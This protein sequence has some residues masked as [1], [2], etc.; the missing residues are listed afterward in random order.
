[1]RFSRRVHIASIGVSLGLAILQLASPAKA[2]L[3]TALE[4]R[5]LSPEQAELRPAVD[6]KGVVIFSDPPHTIFI[7]DGTAGTFFRWGNGV[8]PK[9]GDEVQVRGK[10]FPG[11]Y[12]S[13]IENATFEVLAHPGM[14]EALPATYDD[15]MSGRLHYQRV[16]VEG[17]VRTIVP[18]GEGTSLLRIALGSRIVEVQMNQPIET[19]STDWI[20][21]RVK[22]SGLAAGRINARR[23]LVAPY[24]RCRGWSEIVPLSAPV[25]AEAIPNASPEQLLNFAVDGHEGHRVRV[26]GVVLASFNNRELFV[27]D[28]ESAIQVHLFQLPPELKPSPGDL[29][30]VLGFPQM[31]QFS[32]TVADAVIAAHEKKST[33][34]LPRNATISDLL[35]GEL[36]GNFVSVEAVL[37]DRYRSGGLWVMLLQSGNQS[38]QVRSPEPAEDIAAGSTLRVR[39][40]CQVQSTRRSEYRSQPESIVL[41]VSSTDHIEVLRTAS[42]W[43]SRRLLTVLI[44]TLIA[45]ALAI[46]WIIRQTFAIRRRIEHEAV[47][48]ER[49]RI[50]REFHDTLEQELAGLSL[51]LDAATALSEG[52]DKIRNFLAGSR[53][54]IGRIQTETRNLVSDLRDAGN[55]PTDLEAALREIVAD[56]PRGV[57]PEISLSADHNPALPTRAVHH[58]KMIAREAVTNA[59]KHADAEHISIAIVSDEDGGK[60][61]IT[62]DG[63]GLVDQSETHGRSGHFG[64]MGIRERAKKLGVDVAWQCD[65]GTTLTVRLPKP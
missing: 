3:Q 48:E 56:F 33:P 32:A 28:G 24:L 14:P 10:A 45:I 19:A 25:A 50:A 36:D 23:Q 13:G 4:V 26:R 59:V 64:C 5:S 41:R 15:L 61:R 11:L 54:L 49:Q 22:I 30:E 18:E 6:L 46:A 42:W 21:R 62:D 2:Q 58:L 8:P 57:G 53:N 60:M 12:V 17:I 52:H 44:F 20:D 7:Q 39:G 29:V 43:T 63:R 31:E 34:P 38:L 51:R 1:M 16:V 55:S 65:A 47:L 37:V 27:R 9:V 40:I 35:S